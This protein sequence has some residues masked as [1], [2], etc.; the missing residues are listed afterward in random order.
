[1]RLNNENPF[2][3]FRA[4]DYTDEQINSLW[5][6][7]GPELV[8]A[9]IEPSSSISKYV[10]GGKG[11]GKTHLLRYFSYPAMRLRTADTCP[12]RM[13]A[14]HGFLAVFLRATTL[15][16]LRFE[17][18]E[19][20]RRNWQ[21]LFGVYLEL[22]LLETVV[23]T[24]LDMRCSAREKA[25]DD[26]G[27][28]TALSG[29]A[30][31]LADARIQDVDTLHSWLVQWRRHIDDSINNLAFGNEIDIRVPFRIGALSLNAATALSKWC[32]D[33]SGV[34]I[35]Y[36][37]DEVE[38]FSEQQQEV[39]NSLVRF[40]AGQAT[41]RI[42]G[43]LY[44]VKTL[45]II[46]SGE[47]NREGSE[48]QKVVLDELLAQW[49]G[50]G[51]FAHQFIAKRM[52][53]GVGRSD[54]G[55][56]HNFTQLPAGLLE[57][58]DRLRFYERAID[59]LGIERGKLSFKD[60][61]EETFLRSAAN[62]E[63][64]TERLR[65]VSELTTELPLIIQKLNLLLFAKKWKRST[66]AARVTETAATILNQ[67][68]SFVDEG[69][70]TR[71]GYYANAYQQWAPDL[72]AQICRSSP[73]LSGAPYAGF[74]MAVKIAR[75]NPRNLLVFFNRLYEICTFRQVRFGE[76]AALDIELQ[77]EAAYQA[78]RFFLESDSNYGA[79]VD[80][81]R[82]AVE[83]LGALLRTARYALNI[84]EVSPLAFSYW[85]GGLT[86]AA[87]ATIERALNYSFIF[88]LEP[89]RP[90]RNTERV[91]RKAM[92]NPLLAPKWGLPVSHR[93]DLALSSD[94]ANAVFDP[95]QAKEFDAERKRLERKWNDPF[96]G[97]GHHS[98]Q[99]SLPI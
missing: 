42:T 71:K 3:L 15:D 97:S 80:E 34:T 68:R 74:S 38:N 44:A 67:S 52:G 27:F 62:P 30:K 16:P 50:F 59:S 25:F 24:M 90:D 63:E 89:G 61:Y 65:A 4:S 93:G 29:Q 5:V 18:D 19:A 92:L 85:E 87:A 83:R 17:M 57:E 86:S 39:I 48:F 46:G 51:Q 84:P 94:L 37:I 33:L 45:A 66:S 78:A 73:P 79:G 58:L 6:D 13:V 69:Q 2:K 43:R 76:G 56:G 91:N 20:E 49:P 75:G 10:L 99:G 35:I 9:V 7:I 77:S 98:Q 40:G 54:P 23:E 36:M 55:P 95:R 88:S 81:A 64:R 21:L 28:V 72:F 96:G 1:M 8:D 14:E 22:R 26:P 53:L 41:F 82:T 12:V 31:A 47:R 70:P 60:V 32:A 11:T